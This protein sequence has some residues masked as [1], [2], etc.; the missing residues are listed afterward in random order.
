MSAIHYL[1]HATSTQDVLHGLAAEGAPAGTA[2][3]AAE[4]GAGRGSRGRQWHS[5]RGGLWLSVLLR[6]VRSV[7]P[8]GVE[9]LSLRVGLAV[10][11]ALAAVPGLP[12][13]ALKWPND[14]VLADGKV[15]GILCEARWQGDRLTWVAVGVGLNVTNR[16]PADTAMPAT[17]LAAYC[18]ELTAEALA[19]PIARAVAGLAVD[20]PLLDAAELAAFAARDWLRGR[21][22][23]APVAGRA[24][25]VAGDGALIVRRREGYDDHVRFGSIALAEQSSDGYDP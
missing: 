16:L 14:L 6:P 10:A 13:V 17:C 25:G 12:P 23:S 7:R 15:G 3:V 8:V 20:N 4:Q 1:E 5:P 2:V 18:P 24:A 21:A 9:V 19:E 22:L 11:D